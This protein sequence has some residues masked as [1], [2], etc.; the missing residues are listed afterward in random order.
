MGGR[1]A[2]WIKNIPT[3]T[4]NDEKLNIAEFANDLPVS[5]EQKTDVMKE[6]EK[7]NI[8]VYNSMLKLKEPV[9]ERQLNTILENCKKYGKYTE[10]ISKENQMQ[11]KLGKFGASNTLACFSQDFN[12]TNQKIYYNAEFINQ[13]LSDI[14]KM[15]KKEIGSGFWVQT[16]KENWDRQITTHEYGHF[17]QNNV[18]YKYI[19]RHYK[20][21][22]AELVKCY[23]SEKTNQNAQNLLAFRDKL[24]DNMNNKICDIARKKFG[25]VDE[26]VDISRYG[27]E[28]KVEYFAELYTNM[29]LS[30]NPTKLAKALKLYLGGKK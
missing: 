1:G 16:D 3:S 9:L 2:S 25:T 19:K 6:L 29:R 14:R 22:Y 15:S 28:K 26:N 11:V 5:E 24:C 23:E 12:Y 21:E 30:S 17:V 4:I 10:L 7:R 27:K 20:K 18:L 8:V 13:S